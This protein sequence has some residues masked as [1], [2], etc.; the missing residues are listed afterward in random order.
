MK[1]RA[2]LLVALVATLARGV[3]AQDVCQA[4]IEGN[5]AVD[6]SWPAPLDRTI[7]LDLR[8]VKLRD[9]LEQ[10]A[11]QAAFRISYSTDVLPLER[12][13]CVTIHS[14]PAGQLLSALLAGS[15]AAAVV[16]AADHIVLAPT[17]RHA[18][19]LRSPTDTVVKLDSLIVL[20]E[21][22]QHAA[23]T[24]GSTVVLNGAALPLNTASTMTRVLNGAA[25]GVWLWQ[26][27]GSALQ[28][29]S[30]RGVSSFGISAPK[31]YID[32]IP[33]ANPLVA[34]RF[35][36]GSIE[37]VEI[38][39]APDGGAQF[40]GDAMSGVTSIV[41]RH[42][43]AGDGVPHV[44]LRSAM[45]V[46]SS[47]FVVGSSMTQDHALNLRLGSPA[48][49]TSVNLTAGNGGEVL[50]G[51]FVRHVAG[52]ASVRALRNH[53]MVTGMLR[54][55]S[56]QSGRPWGVPGIDSIIIRDDD[57]QSLRQYTAGVRV[58][59]QTSARWTH[60]FLA[61]IDGF[62][63]GGVSGPWTP[64]LSP[65]DSALRSVASAQR[66]T[67]RLTSTGRVEVGEQVTASLV[68][69]AEHSR[70]R[71]RG[72]IQDQTTAARWNSDTQRFSPGS[73]SPV[74]ASGDGAHLLQDITGLGIQANTMLRERVNLSG[75][76]RIERH[77]ANGRMPQ[78][79]ALPTVGAAVHHE[80]GPLG[81]R[82]RVTAGKGIRWPQEPAT[83]PA[84]Q[85]I[86]HRV[87]LEPEQQAGVE[88]GVDLSYKGALTLQVTRFDQTASKL[89]QRTTVT[90]ANTSAHLG[91]VYRLQ[92][93][94]EISNDGWELQAGLKHG[95]L[96]L[97]SGFSTVDSR[98][99]QVAPGYTGDLR[100]GDRML[101]VPARTLNFS[102]AWTTAQWSSSVTAVRAFDWVNYDRRTLN[103]LLAASDSGIGGQQLRALWRTYDG[104]T[105]VRA[106]ATRQLNE[107]IGLWLEIDN[108][109]NRQRGEPDNASY[110]P[111]RTIA[112]GVRASF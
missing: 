7:S 60:S 8:D 30:V 26:Q 70:L 59:H 64:Y 99:Q 5:S 58:V 97:G 93:V 45:G 103:H 96:S 50:P 81:I 105:H 107:G 9:L 71:Q 110:L 43:L 89:I 11:G 95:P 84:A 57:V 112:V 102:A 3:S 69:T 111:G 86:V 47:D 72:V 42:D 4:R 41:T 48:L 1:W 88:A 35:A 76:V 33:V 53:T 21:Q 75:G 16:A 6:R 29:G 62:S 78:I 36:P 37:R 77:R 79:A 61:G 90:R 74:D 25:P 44:Q 91:D 87:L 80:E 65:A 38:L 100:A 24:A 13:Y 63:I 22:H 23:E 32:G 31:V 10:V 12:T 94:G 66:S 67:F 85:H 34:T 54:F 51:S 18:S 55:F 56:E 82:L 83:A 28:Y 17:T 109:L 73:Y 15:G 101:A 98:V 106:T 52:D 108:V 19:V 20:G 104:S 2:W 39:R 68:A 46:S 27:T 92:N 40:G 49:S 14:A